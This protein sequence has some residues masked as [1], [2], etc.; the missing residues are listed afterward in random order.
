ME[1]F[2]STFK[3]AN[4]DTWAFSEDAAYV[5]AFSIIMLNTDLHNASIADSKR[6]TLEVRL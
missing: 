4:E 3:A 5:L 2:A 6:M 1:K